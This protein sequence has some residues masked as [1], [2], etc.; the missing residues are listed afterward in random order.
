MIFDITPVNHII[1]S[2]ADWSRTAIEV[3]VTEQQL[4]ASCNE[5]LRDLEHKFFIRMRLDSSNIHKN[6]W[7]TELLQTV[8]DASYPLRELL[9]TNTTVK[10]NKDWLGYWEVYSAVFIPSWV[11]RLQTRIA[12]TQ[13]GKEP[14]A[15]SLRNVPLRSFHIRDTCADSI[16]SMGK[17]INQI[18]F[19][20]GAQLNWDWLA[21]Y[22][23]ADNEK[24]EIVKNKDRWYLGV[25]GEGQINTANMR[26][27]KNKI[28][29]VLKTVDHICDNS[30]KEDDKPLG[31]LFALMNVAPNG[32]ATIKIPRIASEALVS[33]I[34]LF[35]LCFKKTVIIHTIANDTLFLCG[36]VFL[37]NLTS[38]NC[39]SLCEFCEIASGSPYI[40]LFSLSY[41]ESD[42]YLKT[43][44]NLTTINNK[45]NQWR[46]DYYTKLLTTHEKLCK[47][48][49]S[50]MFSSYV[51]NMLKDVYVDE[52]QKWCKLTNFNFFYEVKE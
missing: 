26:A 15:I 43:Y 5:K 40:S 44:N 9:E 32:S 49:S 42:A 16:N 47:S 17:A 12:S 50:K 28:I 18:E 24:T 30:E 38:R 22:T 34:H 31:I 48:A 2:A 52:S 27:W 1:P 51:E 11:Q 23:S 45:I 20:A 36:D 46:I 33:C 8:Y 25:D 14:K 19:N 4:Q 3:K 6:K 13:R 35:T 39:K 10:I 7:N 41:M 37:N 21:T 29:T